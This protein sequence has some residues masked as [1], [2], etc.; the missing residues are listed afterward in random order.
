MSRLI[1]DAPLDAVTDTVALGPG[2]ARVLEIAVAV[3]SVRRAFV[4]RRVT[5]TGVAWAVDLEVVARARLVPLPPRPVAGRLRSGVWHSLLVR[6]P[7][8]SPGDTARILLPIGSRMLE[9]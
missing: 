1:G 6:F 2:P 3:A 8:S 5:E 7:A 4:E 9:P